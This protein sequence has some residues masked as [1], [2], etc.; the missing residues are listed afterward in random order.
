[1]RN[2]LLLIAS[3]AT[4]PAIACRCRPPPE[5]HALYERAQL[6][7]QAKVVQVLAASNVMNETLDRRRATQVAATI[8][9]VYKGDPALAGG[10]VVLKASGL[11]SSC[12]SLPPQAVGQSVT[13]E[14]PAPYRWTDAGACSYVWSPSGRP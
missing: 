10:Q 13:L 2:V 8:T 6:L 14:G 12:F 7:V 11:G 3:L 9:K 4:A 5:N 1:M